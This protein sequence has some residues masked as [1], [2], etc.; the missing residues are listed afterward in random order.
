M[1]SNT[2]RQAPL[3]L[4]ERA[5][6]ADEAPVIPAPRILDAAPAIPVKVTVLK[7]ILV[8]QG[9]GKVPTVRPTPVVVALLR[10]FNNCRELLRQ[11][12]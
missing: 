1:R 7:V 8:T 4:A 12:S 10:P 6:R 11:G 9:V 2:S 5:G 3:E